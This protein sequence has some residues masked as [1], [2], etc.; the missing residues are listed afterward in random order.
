M[1]A[2][3]YILL[4]FYHGRLPWKGIYAPSLEAKRK[5]MGE[6]KAEG[7]KPLVDFLAASEPEFARYIK[8]VKSLGFVDEP[9]YSFLKGLFTERMKKEG[10]VDDGKFDWLL[11][12]KT[13]V[14]ADY[15]FGETI[16][17]PLWIAYHVRY[18]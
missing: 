3:G 10:W 16:F 13:L 9:N 5:M 18:Y 1:E 6:M 2:L 7:S 12:G 17:P 11:D 8:H 14:P 15:R 4:H